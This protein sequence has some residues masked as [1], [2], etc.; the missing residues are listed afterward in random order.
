VNQIMGTATVFLNQNLSAIKQTHLLINSFTDSLCVLCALCGREVFSFGA[1]GEPVRRRRGGIQYQPI[2]SSPHS[3][4]SLLKTLIL[5]TM[6]LK[7]VHKY[8][9]IYLYTFRCHSCITR[10]FQNPH[11]KIFASNPSSKNRLTYKMLA[12]LLTNQKDYVTTCRV[13][14]CA[15]GVLCGKY[16]LQC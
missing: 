14:L 15:L 9:R 4:I 13:I 8:I 5:K 12:V 1:E 6:T 11:P 7:A 2:Y 10:H 3:Q 16:I